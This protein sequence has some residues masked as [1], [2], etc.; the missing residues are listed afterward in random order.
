MMKKRNAGFTLIELLV[1]IAIIAIL[2]AI[3]FPVYMNA[4]RAAKSTNCK[5]NMK[6]IATAF[7]S[8]LDDYMA[9]PGDA[10]G[11][12]EWGKWRG[13]SDPSDQ[14]VGWAEKIYRYHSKIDIYKCP[15]RPKINFG[16]SMNASY[17]DAVKTTRR[18]S[19]LIMV[20]EA[21]GQGSGEIN[22][23]AYNDLTT[24]DSDLTG[25]KPTSG[26]PYE[27][28][29]PEADINKFGVPNPD[30]EDGESTPE[31]RSISKDLFVPGP[32]NGANNIVLADGHVDVI[33]GDFH[34]QKKY[35]F[36]GK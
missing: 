4:Q 36:S 8:Y 25:H 9:A 21:A 7:Q 11:Q 13:M 2:A 3:L 20:F 32:H 5:S 34:Q 22:P 16:Y 23:V 10:G 15:S 33:Q 28:Y 12:I 6:Q 1:V 35:S 29:D 18:L 27:K 31:E 19:D 17:S 24:G 26:L 30:P 14:D